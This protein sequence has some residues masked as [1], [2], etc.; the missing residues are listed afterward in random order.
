MPCSRFCRRAIRSGSHGT[1]SRRCDH[2]SRATSDQAS[3]STRKMRC[4]A[5]FRVDERANTGQNDRHGARGGCLMGYSAQIQRPIRV[6]RKIERPASRSFDRMNAHAPIHMQAF[7]SNCLRSVVVPRCRA[8]K[9]ASPTPNPTSPRLPHHC[10]KDIRRSHPQL[11]PGHAGVV[12]L[13]PGEVL[14]RRRSQRRTSPTPSPRTASAARFTR[15]SGNT[16]PTSIRR[17]ISPRTA[18][19][20]TRSA[21]ADDPAAGRARYDARSHRSPTTPS[22]SPT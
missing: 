21:Q 6:Y 14:A 16:A 4:C 9:V 17:R 2:R 20:W 13:R 12:G 22:R 11:R 5:G 15:W 19:P 7:G 1:D 3:G 18:S 8:R 10:V